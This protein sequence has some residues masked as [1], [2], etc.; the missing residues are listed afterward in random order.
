MTGRL[1]V[2]TDGRI[3]GPAAITYNT[4]FPCVNGSWG[5]G[6]ITG[7][8]MHTMVGTQAGTIAW[9]NN[10][11][12]QA[13]A[14]FGVGFDG[15]IHQFGPIGQGWIAWHAG[16]ANA[17]WYG[18]EHEDDGD[19]SRPLTDAQLTASAQLTEMLCGFAGIPLQVTNSP[20]N[21]GLGTHSMGGS[22]WGGH[23][24]PGDVRAAQ[25]GEVIRRA[26]AIR[27]GGSAPQPPAKPRQ[28]EAVMQIGPGE[29]AG[30]SW[31]GDAYSSIGFL[32]DP[33]GTDVVALRVAVHRISGG[34]DVTEVELTNAAPKAVVRVANPSDGCS[35]SRRD[36]VAV[37]I[38]PNFAPR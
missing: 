24:C 36:Q 27:G 10:P 26:Q 13:S 19:P 9:F 1:T 31:N 17:T 35:I 18:I 12:A 22:A 4:P 34:Y 33:Q 7:V 15:A 2:G 3:T 5:S 16:A 38:V 32:A 29:T 11:Q 25:R 30:M 20:A 6:A 8:I 14:Q 28:E 21:W 23:A 37:D